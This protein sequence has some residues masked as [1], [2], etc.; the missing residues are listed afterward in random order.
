MCVY[1]Y[2]YHSNKK[3]DIYTKLRE[4]ICHL[5]IL[6]NSNLPSQ[7]LEY[8]LSIIPYPPE[9]KSAICSNPDWSLKILSRYQKLQSTILIIEYL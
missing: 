5:W 8:S 6:V 2:L 7:T 1:H 9:L 3:M 4:T